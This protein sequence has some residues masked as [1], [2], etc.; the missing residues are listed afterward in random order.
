MEEPKSK[1]FNY[2]DVYKLNDV[3]KIPLKGE[4]S[5]N[6]LFSKGIELVVNKVQ[7][8]PGFEKLKL[9]PELI[10]LMCN[11]IE[12]LSINTEATRGSSLKTHGVNKKDMLKEGYKQLYSLNVD[13]LEVLDKQVQFLFNHKKI[14]GRRT[15]YKLWDGLIAILMYIEK[16]GF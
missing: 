7:S 6:V 3:N 2:D 9:D 15:K 1:L 10:L 4:L 8:I 5:T 11:F 14:V 16:K 13:E 12:E